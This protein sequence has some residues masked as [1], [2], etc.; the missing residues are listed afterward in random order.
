MYQTPPNALWP[1]VLPKAVAL[2]R[3]GYTNAQIAEALDVSIKNI[4]FWMG[5]TP[6]RIGGHPRYDYGL[7]ERARYLRECGYNISQIAE[8]MKIPRS[9][10]GDWL[11]GMKCR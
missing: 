4:Q 11:N 2:R 10:I 8:E 9:T 7:H 3:Q 1:E 5:A 6:R